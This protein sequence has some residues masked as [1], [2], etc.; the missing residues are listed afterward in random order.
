M[1]RECRLCP[2][3]CGADRASGQLGECRIGATPLVA[4]CGPHFGEEAA[5]VGTGGSGTIFFSG[6][7]LHCAFCQNADISQHPVGTPVGPDGLA[8]LMI[9]LERR[10]CGN[11]NFVS[12]TH[13]AHAVAEAIVLARRCGFSAPVVYNCGG[14][15]SVEVLRSLAGLV[16]IYMPD[17]KYGDPEAGRRYSRVDDYPA[18]AEAALA[19]MFRQVGPLRVDGRGVAVRGVLVRH[20]VM[21]AD[22]AGGQRVVDTV[23]RVA[24]GAALNI[25]A[26]YHPAHEA[27]RHPELLGRPDPGALAALRASLAGRGLVDASR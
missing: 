12:P 9:G 22:V 8:D 26:Q 1:L 24:P 13:V 25:M 10:G 17:F 21:P 18:V 2:R 4:S 14:Y 6:C 3:H 5:L 15:E 27:H 16:E 11:V 7:N 20:L 19:E 23:A